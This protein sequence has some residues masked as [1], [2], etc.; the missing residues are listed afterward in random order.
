M[1]WWETCTMDTDSA[2]VESMRVKLEYQVKKLDEKFWP[3]HAGWLKQDGDS[4]L[5][6]FLYGHKFKHFKHDELLAFPP[7]VS[8]VFLLEDCPGMQVNMI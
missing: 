5:K 1:L 2:L 8:Q 3:T 6:P 4:F 7:R